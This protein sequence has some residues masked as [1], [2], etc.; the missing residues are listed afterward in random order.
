MTSPIHYF[1][2]YKKTIEEEKVYGNWA[3]NWLYNSTLGGLVGQVLAHGK[4]FNFF[5]GLAQNSFF[6]KRKIDPFVKKFAIEME[7]F[8]ETPYSSFNQFFIRRFKEGKRNFVEAKEQM[9]AFC[10]GRYFGHKALSPEQTVPVKG[11]YLLGEQ[12]LGNQK[13]GQ[14]FAHGP[15]LI[16]RLCPTDY[17]RFHF[18]DRGKVLEHY[19]LKGLLHSVNPLALTKRPNIFATNYR[20]VTILESENFG[21]LAYI[22]VGAMG[23]GKIVQSASKDNF[24]RGEEKGYFLF[25]GSSVILLGTKGAWSPTEDI[26][27]NT[28]QGRETFVRLGDIVAHGK[29]IV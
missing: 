26:L 23:V 4:I 18:P 24:S 15:I 17:H 27:D 29:K 14:V 10:E 2:R 1:N 16:A 13:W 22:E 6:S 7:D 5:Y 3:I 19:P 11:K 12:L 8:E 25:G 21:L 9:P 20:E 28:A